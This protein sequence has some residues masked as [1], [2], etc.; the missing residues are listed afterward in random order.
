M[1]SQSSEASRDT[2]ADSLQDDA[3]GAEKRTHPV[4]GRFEPPA[5]IPH[6][7]YQSV[8][9]RTDASCRSESRPG[10][11]D[12]DGELGEPTSAASRHVARL[13]LSSSMDWRGEV[14]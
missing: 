4:Q 13:V 5:R 8:S 6:L 7:T 10:G 1:F 12:G 9:D 3:A 11:V 2:E 14:L